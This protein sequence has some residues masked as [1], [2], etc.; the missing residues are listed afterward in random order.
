MA[1]QLKVNGVTLATEESG[2]V[3]LEAPQIKDSSNNVIL[4]QSGTTPVLKNIEV[5][6]NSSMMFRNRI[7]NG[8]MRID[9]RNAG[10][11]ITATN[12]LCLDRW[13]T[14]SSQTSK[15]SVEQ[16]TDSPNSFNYSLKVTS[17]SSY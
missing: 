2:T 16:S 9:Q 6:N 13:T 3:T 17:L 1:G 14:R 10:G 11:S 4:D 5:V 7:I 8:D 15:Y 12:G